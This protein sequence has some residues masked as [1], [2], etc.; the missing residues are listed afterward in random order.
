MKFPVRSP[1]P[2][3]HPTA[4]TLTH[5]A[6][7]WDDPDFLE[8]SEGEP[9]HLLVAQGL[10]QA[11]AIR[12][13]PRA[14]IAEPAT[15]ARSK[16]LRIESVNPGRPANKH[17]E[18]PSIQI[19][20][21]GKGIVRLESQE[22]APGV[23][24]GDS[25]PPLQPRTSKPRDHAQIF[26]AEWGKISGHS[27]RWIWWAGG[28]VLAMVLIGLAIQP[29]LTDEDQ[30]RTAESYQALQVVDD[31]VAV[32]D[33]M[34]YFSEN[35]AQVLGE[36]QEA[37]KTYA[38]ART[39][40]EALPVIRNADAL[41]E[42]LAKDWRSWNVP[43]DW[44]VSESDEISYASVGKLPYVV[45]L[46][47]RS[48]FSRYQVFLVREDGR[49]Q[50]DWEATLGLGSKTFEEMKS[51]EIRKAEMRVIMSPI[52][53][54]SQTFPESQYRAYR[55]TFNTTDDILWGYVPNG[56]PAAAALA[57]IFNEK[58]VFSDKPTQQAMRLRLTRGPAG[59]SLNQWVVLDV[60][61]KGWV[62]P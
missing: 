54:Y 41:K 36:I 26:S 38:R 51:P 30:D 1:M 45:I 27:T 6:L 47:T 40:E 10:P 14:K 61:H 13:E 50:V 11:R 31:L 25:L 15:P 59:A 3:P 37:L 44:T 53:Y 34:V 52:S 62:T 17:D 60:L 29:L 8:S 28:G 49:M 56:S 35:P 42:R 7:E 21:H 48:D 5:D 43:P 57:E 2:E 46:G 19:I 20:E 16:G 55:L 24:R 9:A 18:K 4:E 22:P 23:A 58:A 32:D 33:P 12:P 39:L